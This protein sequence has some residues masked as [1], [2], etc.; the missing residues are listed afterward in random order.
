MCGAIREKKS[1]KRPGKRTVLT[2]IPK[3]WAPTP[4]EIQMSRMLARGHRNLGAGSKDGGSA[5]V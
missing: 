3:D 4:K 1:L 2:G 5:F